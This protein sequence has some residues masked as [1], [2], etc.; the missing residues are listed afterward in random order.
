MS[1]TKIRSY[2]IVEQSDVIEFKKTGKYK[3]KSYLGEGSFGEVY[4]VQKMEENNSENSKIFALKI[5]KKYQAQKY[6]NSENSRPNEILNLEIKELSTLNMVKRINNPYLMKYVDWKIHGKTKE[7]M[8]LMEY[9]DFDLNT[10]FYQNIGRNEVINETFFKNIVFQMLSALN[11][12]HKNGIIHCDIKPQ[13]ILY[14]SKENIIQIIDYGLSQRISFDVKKDYKATGGTFPY[15]APD[16]LLGNTL[17]F[18]SWDIWSLGC[19]LVE[20][21][22]GKVLFPGNSYKEVLEKIVDIFGSIKELLPGFEFLAQKRKVIL[23]EREGK[24]L[25]NFIK[26]NQ[27]FKFLNDD[28]YDLVNSMLCI[29]PTKRISAEEA[30]KHSWLK[31][32][33]PL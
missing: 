6:P 13:N 8:V 28:F 3:I 32:I 33:I 30:M 14:K 16:I 20:L 1:G 29:D 19:V 11:A 26:E 15:M 25:I 2:D 5:F 7:I 4:K 17:F 10:F 9:L 12:L 21:C 22:T 27:K 24:G 23:S 31:N 18:K